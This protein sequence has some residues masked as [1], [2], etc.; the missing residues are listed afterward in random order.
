MTKETEQKNKTNTSFP[1]VHPQYKYRGEGQG[2]GRYNVRV[3]PEKK[4]KEKQRRG[5]N[6][7]SSC[8]CSLLPEHFSPT[9]FPKDKNE[10]FRP[11]K[12]KDFPCLACLTDDASQIMLLLRG[13][14]VSWLCVRYVL[15]IKTSRRYHHDKKKRTRDPAAR[16]RTGGWS[17]KGREWEEQLGD[18]LSIPCRTSLVPPKTWVRCR[19]M[20]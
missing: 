11:K 20:S 6:K 10:I 16:L 4:K 19:D 18:G 13:V 8:C 2:G 3:Y 1:G 12:A 17:G 9:R 7:P 5:G 14:V 15:L